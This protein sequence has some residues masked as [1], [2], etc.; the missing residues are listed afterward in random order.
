MDDPCM[1]P[2]DLSHYVIITSTDED[3]RERTA[4][5]WLCP[6]CATDRVQLDGYCDDGFAFTGALVMP[7]GDEENMMVIE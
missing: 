2:L 4:H 7:D 1:C 6:S 3:G 5:K